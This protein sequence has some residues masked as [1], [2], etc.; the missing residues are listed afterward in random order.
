MTRRVSLHVQLP[1]ELADLAEQLQEDD[2]EWLEQTLR[3]ALM[4]RAVNEPE[5]IAVVRTHIKEEL[6]AI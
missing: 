6:A 1:P 3:Y 5:L 4:R 2:P